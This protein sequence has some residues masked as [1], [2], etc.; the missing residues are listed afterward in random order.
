[1][2]ELKD[3]DI[4]LEGINYLCAAFKQSVKS[5]S[6]ISGPLVQT[7]VRLAMQKL[8]FPPPRVY[9]NSADN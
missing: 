7:Q 1:M 4:N 3:W 5:C 9:H 6:R 2:K 8:A